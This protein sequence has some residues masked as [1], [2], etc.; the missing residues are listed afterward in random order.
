MQSNNNQLTTYY[1]YRNFKDTKHLIDIFENKRLFASDFDKFNDPMDSFFEHYNEANELLEDMKTSKL[2]NKIL[3]LC[4]SPT[5]ILMWTHYADEHK[6]IAIGI[7]I[8][9]E[10]VHKVKYSKDLPLFDSSKKEDE[11]Y[12]KRFVKKL[13][14]T[15]LFPWKYEKEVRTL[16][17]SN[18]V[19]IKITKII[20][21]LKTSE[22]DKEMVKKYFSEVEHKDENFFQEMKLEYLDTAFTFRRL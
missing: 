2:K 9:S 22:D 21:G 15:K 18:F 10:K 8:S 14:T 6:G 3:S 20:F 16:S 1:K 17:D 5:N 13:L 4:K 12:K 7:E 19:D 11:I